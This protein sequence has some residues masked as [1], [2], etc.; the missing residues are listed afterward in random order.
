[1]FCLVSRICN[2]LRFCRV[3]R[4]LLLFIFHR[5]EIDQ[6]SLV[7]IDLQRINDNT[8]S[9]SHLFEP[10][11]PIYDFTE[12]FHISL[13]QSPFYHKDMQ[14]AHPLLL[15]ANNQFSVWDKICENEPLRR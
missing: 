13:V 3:R 10:R 11:I 15:N 12:R 14:T 9:H 5:A 2:T 4:F 1:M 8:I 7:A 6:V